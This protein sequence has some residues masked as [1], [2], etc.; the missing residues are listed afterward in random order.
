M[1]G[2]VKGYRCKN[3]SI[4]YTVVFDIPPRPGQIRRQKKIRGFRTKKAA[5]AKLRTILTAV[6]KTGNYE[7]QTK[8]TV[9]QYAQQWL[10]EVAHR[11]K[12]RTHASYKGWILDH[13]VPAIG[14]LP[15]PFVTPQT[16]R[17]FYIEQLAT[18]RKRKKGVRTG[19]HP[20]SVRHIHRVAHAMFADASELM[21]TNPCANLKKKLPRVPSVEQCVLDESRAKKLIEKAIGTRLHPLIVLALFTGARVGELLALTWDYADPDAGRVAFAFGITES[22]QLVEQKRDRSR[23]TL[24]LPPVAAAI[25]KTHKA[26]Q[27][28][29]K[30]AKGALYDDRGFVFA[31]D[32]GNP[33]KVKSLSTLFRAIVKSA[34]L[35]PDVHL[36]T[37]RHTYA[38]LSLQAGVPVTTVSA[39]L[40]HSN[41]AT[42]LRVYA[43]HIPST[44]DAAADAMQ[45]AFAGIAGAG[46]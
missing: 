33:W 13:V 28:A 18:G 16:M 38:S 12:P 39:N 44:E 4:Y 25:L 29:I 36:H 42:T 34:G 30:L 32:L 14:H 17:D 8:L 11:V 46:T 37:L 43:H 3:G 10:A 27:A 6:D 26:R 35:T 40:G 2:S 7:E 9:E 15:L 5:E 31:D 23:R 22:G 24:S 20:Q 21:P 19:L 45:K 41:V 1:Q